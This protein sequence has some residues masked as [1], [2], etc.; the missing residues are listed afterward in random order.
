M[1]GATR[2][3]EA[4]ALFDAGVRAHAAGRTD[5]GIEAI[6]AA[7]RIEPD[8]PEALSFGGFILQQRGHAVGALR[9]YDRALALEPSDAPTWFNRGVLLFGAKRYEDARESLE[10]ACTLRPDAAGYHCNLGAALYEL[11]RL[12]ARPKSTGGLSRSMP[13]WRRRRSISATP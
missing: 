2:K 7:L 10:R 11:G 4:R 1:Q 13:I 12:P 8:F 5:Q 6:D 3:A 9:F